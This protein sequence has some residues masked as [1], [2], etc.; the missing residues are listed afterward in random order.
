[1]VSRE[2]VPLSAEEFVRICLKN[3]LRLDAEAEK[4]LKKYVDLLLEWNSKI[5]LI[6]RKDQENVWGA[7]ILHA[8]SLLFRVSMPGGIRVLDLGTGGGLPGVPLAILRKDIDFVVLDSIRKKTTA[9]ESM[10]GELG[11]VNCR[12]ETGRAEALGRE[13]RGRFDGVLARAVASLAEL[14]RWGKLV[15]RSAGGGGPAMEIEGRKSFTVPWLIAYKGG[16]VTGEV[17]EAKVKAGLGRSCEI[18]L[19]FDGSLEAG[20]EGKKLIVVQL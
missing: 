14:V 13:A 5:N 16:D 11:L 1:M 17:E 20:L 7:Q 3:G 8:V 10:V 19:V 2:T 6:S 4:Q 18:P 12:V 15:T 9:V